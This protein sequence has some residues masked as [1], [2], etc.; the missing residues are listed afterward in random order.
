[1]AIVTGGTRGIGRSIVDQLGRDGFTVVFTHSNSDTAAKELEIEGDAQGR[2][3]HGIRLDVTDDH[4]PQILLDFAENLGAVAALVNN[5]GITG[6]IS[7]FTDLTDEDLRR[8]VD[9]N[10]IAPTRLCR[11]VARRW[12]IDT[13]SAST[14]AGRAIVNISS[15]AAHTGAPGEYIAY[16]AAKAGVETMT[17]GLAKELA[18]ADIRVNAVSP[19]TT[20]TTIHARAGE[21]G[22]AQ[23]VAAS[24]PLGRPGTPTEIAEAVAWLLSPHA[25]YVTGAVLNV[26]GGL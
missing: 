12:A 13:S 18:P 16:A 17:L 6:P 1:M 24:I 2:I 8:V 25:S 4:A 19:G 10:L 26:S 23:R 7:P 3:I 21:P 5:A 22:R 14:S 9:V 15:V 11:E 20:D